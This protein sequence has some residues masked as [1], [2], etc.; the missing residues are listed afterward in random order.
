M[1]ILIHN[2]YTGKSLSLENTSYEIYLRCGAVTLLEIID[3]HKRDAQAIQKLFNKAKV[4]KHI[5]LCHSVLQLTARYPLFVDP[6]L[7]YLFCPSDYNSYQVL[8]HF[9]QLNKIY[10]LISKH[11]LYVQRILYTLMELNYFITHGLFV[12]CFNWFQDNVNDP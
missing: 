8:K 9:E 6:I 3:I 1:Y 12:E 10:C 4:G 5:Y 7:L 2:Y 11:S